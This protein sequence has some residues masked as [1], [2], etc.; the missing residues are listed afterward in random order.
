MA[1]RRLRG[2]VRV[3]AERVFIESGLYSRLLGDINSQNPNRALTA[4]TLVR[5]VD[6][7]G[8]RDAVQSAL[9]HPFPLVRLA[10]RVAVLKY[11]DDH[12]RP[13][14]AAPCSGVRGDSGF[15]GS[16]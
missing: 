1:M 6:L 4:V 8:A 16:C 11:G 10:A 5:E 15:A 7:D 14:A 9:H 13:K 3:E 2:E 12:A